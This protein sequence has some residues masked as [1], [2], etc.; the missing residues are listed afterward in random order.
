ME[1]PAYGARI[2]LLKGSCMGTAEA[3]S[4]QFKGAKL[5]KTM[6]PKKKAKLVRRLDR[7]GD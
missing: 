1:D 4:I 3:C 5:T 6:C 2:A 7:L